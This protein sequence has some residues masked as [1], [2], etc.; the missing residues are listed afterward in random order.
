MVCPD[1][2]RYR[3]DLLEQALLEGVKRDLLSPAAWD[4][5]QTEL[6]AQLKSARPDPAHAR[7]ELAKAKEEAANIL[8]AIKLGIVTPEH[9]R[10][11][12]GR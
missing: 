6:R 11:T 7:K 1:N 5:F 12:D 9:Q 3:R 10:C 4:A 8:A 2:G